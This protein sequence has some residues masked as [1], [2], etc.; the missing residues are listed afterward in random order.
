MDINAADNLGRTALSW[1]TINSYQ[2]IAQTLLCKAALVDVLGEGGLTP[3]IQTAWNS[4]EEII[5]ALINGKADANITDNNGFNALHRAKAQKRCA[6]SPCSARSAPDKSWPS[7]LLSWLSN[8][9]P[10]RDRLADRI[11][12]IGILQ[13]HNDRG[14]FRRWRG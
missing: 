10:V 2:N 4:H 11:W 7:R 14:Y 6:S 1:T 13:L 12:V 9:M 3:M 5:A 8:P